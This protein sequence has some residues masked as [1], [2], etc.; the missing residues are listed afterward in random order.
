MGGVVRK[1]NLLQVAEA[2]PEAIIPLSNF[3]MGGASAPPNVTVHVY[4]SV[5]TKNQ[6]VDEIYEGLLQKKGRNYSLGL[7]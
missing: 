4:G 7:T 3:G 6:L 2:G 1:H 5:I